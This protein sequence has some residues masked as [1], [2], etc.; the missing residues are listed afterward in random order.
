MMQQAR[1]IK[2]EVVGYQAEK[3][4]LHKEGHEVWSLLSVSGSVIHR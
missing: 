1:L 2:N 4:Y 3:R